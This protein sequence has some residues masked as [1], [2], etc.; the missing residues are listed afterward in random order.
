M[1]KKVETAM[2]GL[3]LEVEESMGLAA[4][5]RAPAVGTA[6][7]AV[8]A[9]GLAPPRRRVRCDEERELLAHEGAVDAVLAGDLVEQAGAAGPSGRAR[10]APRRAA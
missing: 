10:A 5:G 6:G 9:L 7:R 3:R 8:A 2:G 4:R 1:P